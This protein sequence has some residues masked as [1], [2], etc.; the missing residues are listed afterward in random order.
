MKE[1]TL[2][3]LNIITKWAAIFGLSVLGG[4]AALLILYGVAVNYSPDYFR[5]KFLDEAAPWFSTFFTL[6][7]TL[8]TACSAYFPPHSRRADI[9]SRYLTAPLVIIAVILSLLYVSVKKTLLPDHVLNGFALLAIVGALFR[10][11]PFSEEKGFSS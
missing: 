2:H 9:V 6:L 1:N 4:Y 11:L 3:K 7:A 8:A 10:M 5:M